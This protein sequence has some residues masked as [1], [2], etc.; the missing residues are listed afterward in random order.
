MAFCIF[1]LKDTPDITE[2]HVFP[3]ALGGECC[4]RENGRP[5]RIRGVECS[6]EEWFRSLSPARRERL[7]KRSMRERRLL[8]AA[9]KATAISEAPALGQ[10]ILERAAKSPWWKWKPLRA[11]HAKRILPSNLPKRGAIW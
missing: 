7:W 1:C 9:L 2:E 10:I 6:K 8:A 5:I 3:A 11:W 4:I